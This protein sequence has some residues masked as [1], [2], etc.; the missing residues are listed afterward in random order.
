MVTISEIHVDDIGTRFYGT[1]QDSGVVIDLSEAI[2]VT[3][4]FKKPDDTVL[5]VEA[6]VYG[7]GTDG[8]VQY[9]SVEGD[10]DMS[11][12]WNVQTEVQLVNGTWKSNISTFYV[13]DNLS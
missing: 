1:V 12:H 4:F 9:F 5:E 8:I 2:S 10:L 11:G 3:M 7:D 6:E 13:Y